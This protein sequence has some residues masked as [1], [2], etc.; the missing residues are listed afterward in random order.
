M[1]ASGASAAVVYDNLGNASDALAHANNLIWQ[2]QRFDTDNQTY[3]LNSVTLLMSRTGSGDAVLQLWKGPSSPTSVETGTFSLSGT[4]SSVLTPT[5][6]N[7]SGI[8]LTPNTSYWIVLH[9]SAA[10]TSIGWSVTANNS[11][12]GPGFRTEWGE[13]LTSGSTW[14]VTTGSPY[15]MKVEATAVPEPTEVASVTGLA[16]LAGALWLRRRK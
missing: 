12:S 7:A 9:S 15:Q 8:Q 14:V 2:A 13:S 11:G 10:G 16:I 6:F 3:T 4:Y 1:F 5:T